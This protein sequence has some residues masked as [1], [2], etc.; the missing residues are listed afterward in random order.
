MTKSYP[1]AHPCHNWRRQC[2]R[3]RGNGAVSPG[4]GP[5]GSRS[6]QPGCL[7]DEAFVCRHQMISHCTAHY[8]SPLNR[9]GAFEPLTSFHRLLVSCSD[10]AASLSSISNCPSLDKDGDKDSNQT[11]PALTVQ[12]PLPSAAV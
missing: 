3:V 10:E 2:P 8:T 7:A 9:G 11:F 4:P 5:P 12:L 1:N 6:A